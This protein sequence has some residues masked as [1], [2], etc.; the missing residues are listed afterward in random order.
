MKTDNFITV[1]AVCYENGKKSVVS[2][3]LIKEKPLVI[4]AGKFHANIIRTPEDDIVFAAGV[5]FMQKIIET[6]DQIVSANFYSNAESDKAIIKFSEAWNE[7]EY[8]SVDLKTNFKISVDNAKKCVIKLR[9][10]QALHNKTGSAHATMF[11]DD[12]LNPIAFAE[13]VGRHNAFDKAIGKVFMEKNLN[14]AAIA[15][16]SCR[17]NSE[18][19]NKAIRAGIPI[20]IGYGKPT[21]KGVSISLSSGISVAWMVKKGGFFIFTGKNRFISETLSD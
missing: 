3:N 4:E 10:A 9:S 17:I 20:I 14:K 7:N 13:D 18:M 1:D 8:K 6:P 2:Q 11:F 21:S 5:C 12:K 19:I 15:A 16:L